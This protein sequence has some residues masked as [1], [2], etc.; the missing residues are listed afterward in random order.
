MVPTKGAPLSRFRG[1]KALFLFTCIF[2]AVVV[3]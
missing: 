2:F 1:S 3:F